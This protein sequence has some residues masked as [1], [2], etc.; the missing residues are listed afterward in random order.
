MKGNY[1]GSFFIG[2]KYRNDVCNQDNICNNCIY[3]STYSSGYGYCY[4]KYCSKAYITECDE[5]IPNILNR[6]L[7]NLNSLLDDYLAKIENIDCC[8]EVLSFMKLAEDKGIL[9]SE[10]EIMGI[11]F[12]LF[13]ILPPETYS[14]KYT[15][16]YIS[17]DGK[18]TYTK[19][20]N[21]D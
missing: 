4:K 13:C 12:R 10:I 7:F 5:F 8:D 18:T 3:L 15:K 20:E 21:L 19:E 16:I 9:G 1:M 14:E 2:V 11:K 6:K 17:L